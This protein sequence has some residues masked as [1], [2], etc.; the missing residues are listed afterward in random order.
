MNNRSRNNRSGYQQNDSKPKYDL[1]VVQDARLPMPKQEL[2]APF[3]I[4]QIEWQALTDAVFP[5]AKSVAGVMLALSICKARKL[6]VFKKV[7]HIVPM[8]SSKHGCEIETIWPGI[9]E[10]RI[11]ATRTGQY[12]GRDGVKWGR[13]IRR[14]FRAE[15]S[16]QGQGGQ[17]WSSTVSCPE[18]EFPETAQI[19]VYKIIG[20]VRCPFVGPEV[21]FVEMFSGQKGMRVPNDRWQQAPRQMLE[22]CA[23]A[24]ALRAA[25]PEEL[26]GEWFAEEMEGKT[27]HGDIEGRGAIIDHEPQQQQADEQGD[28]QG[29]VEDGEFENADDNAQGGEPE[30]WDAD[31]VA[32]FREY[33]EN[34]LAAC[35]SVKRVDR[36]F[37]SEK[38]NLEKLTAD[39]R[40]MIER[41]FE[42]RRQELSPSNDKGAAQADSKSDPADTDAAMANAAADGEQQ[43]DQQRAAGNP[44]EPPFLRNLRRD[45]DEAET[46]DEVT[47]V[48][49]AIKRSLESELPAV[50]AQADKLIADRRDAIRADA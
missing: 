5:S 8:Y 35:K 16:G 32:G 21:S 27:M 29:D 3:G 25:F 10:A 42:A 33:I 22:K 34:G 23:E 49:S 50:I 46:L 30:F 37:E 24:A 26:G 38:D 9:A 48:Y 13:I 14:A 6:D 18:M 19:T 17:P 36:A 4:G 1:M 40:L 12:A 47:A 20:G 2:L 31:Q 28:Q 41:L 44:S 39:D 15:K 11:T 45:L 7:V 43:Q